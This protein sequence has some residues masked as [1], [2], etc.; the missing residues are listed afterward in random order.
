MVPYDLPGLILLD[1][2]QVLTSLASFSASRGSSQ[3]FD[4][5]SL[6][7]SHLKHRLLIGL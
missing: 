4:R 2:H 6:I 7:H 5:A 3:G 1:Q